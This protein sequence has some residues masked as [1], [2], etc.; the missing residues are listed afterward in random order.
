LQT[1]LLGGKLG[2][3]SLPLIFLLTCRFALINPICIIKEY[4]GIFRKA[5]IFLR[6]NIV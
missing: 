2:R 3:V 1:V 5:Y 6:N 4:K